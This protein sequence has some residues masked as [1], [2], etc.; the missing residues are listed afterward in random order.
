MTPDQD[1]E[2]RLLIKGMMD[3]AIAEYHD[4]LLWCYYVLEPLAWRYR[5]KF[6]ISGS[7]ELRRWWIIL[8][9]VS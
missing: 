8:T 7:L 1:L 9:P 6:K 2:K 3:E 5:S 4:R